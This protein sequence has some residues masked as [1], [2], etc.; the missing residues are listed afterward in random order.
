MSI[1]FK[2]VFIAVSV[3]WN[4]SSVRHGAMHTQRFICIHVTCGNSSKCNSLLI[5]IPPGFRHGKLLN[6]NVN[7]ISVHFLY[8]QNVF[9][10]GLININT[11]E[12]VCNHLPD[13]NYHLFVTHFV[14]F[15]FIS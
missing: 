7:S 11:D 6:V 4:E 1:I 9:K 14:I 10:R 5:W 12:R 13:M 2:C 8:T 3:G 15:I